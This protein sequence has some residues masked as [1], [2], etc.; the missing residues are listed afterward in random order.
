[1][2]LLSTFTTVGFGPPVPLLHDADSGPLSFPPRVET[3]ASASDRQ[4]HSH[5]SCNSH[6]AHV[7]S[8]SLVR[9]VFRCQSLINALEH[10]QF[11]LA[12]HGLG[13]TLALEAFDPAQQS[14]INAPRLLH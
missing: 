8:N 12:G 2:S 11:T 6:R 10:Q 1:M 4:G 9:L 5:L 14:F 7:E 3:L 13:A